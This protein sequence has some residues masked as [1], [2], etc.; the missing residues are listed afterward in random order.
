MMGYALAELHWSEAQFWA[1]TPHALLA[2]ADFA[3]GAF[4]KAE[5]RA[6]FEAFRESIDG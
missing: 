5:G 3:S 2:A 6:E 1:S 4:E